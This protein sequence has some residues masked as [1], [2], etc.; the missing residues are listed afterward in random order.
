MI[1]N[2]ITVES[3]HVKIFGLMQAFFVYLLNTAVHF[4]RYLCLESCHQI[5]QIRSIGCE[6]FL[7]QTEVSR[8]FLSLF[9]SG[10]NRPGEKRLAVKF[11]TTQMSC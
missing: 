7:H 11:H 6:S 1:L 2:S 3:L 10:I 8:L 4:D 9:C 5:L